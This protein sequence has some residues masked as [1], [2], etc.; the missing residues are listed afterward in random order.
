MK[1][2]ALLVCLILQ[3]TIYSMK[4]DEAIMNDRAKMMWVGQMAKA[5]EKGSIDD[6]KNLFISPL[7]KECLK[8]NVVQTIFLGDIFK[9]SSNRIAIAEHFFDNGLNINHPINNPDFNVMLLHLEMKNSN[10]ADFVR[11]LIQKGA[12]VNALA[13]NNI[14]PLHWAIAHK[15]IDAIHLLLEA[16]ADTE[17]KIINGDTA[18]LCFALSCI[19][20]KSWAITTAITS[21]LNMLNIKPNNDTS[22]KPDDTHTKILT[23]LLSYNANMYAKNKDGKT[24]YELL[25]PHFNDFN[26]IV[27]NGRAQAIKYL[28]PR[29]Q[30]KLKADWFKFTQSTYSSIESNMLN[31]SNKSF[32]L[33]PAITSTR[34]SAINVLTQN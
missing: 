2:F 27:Q 9:M 32:N 15:N 29:T 11:L 12:Q 20:Q 23:L 13:K 24:A 7:S 21:V 6:V 34:C 17:I 8:S 33:H 28:A 26:Q 4:L 16:N 5:I 1:Y 3:N 31:I 25:K 10:N 30:Q 14:T 19:P 22:K 18:L